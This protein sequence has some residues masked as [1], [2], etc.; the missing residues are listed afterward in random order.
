MCYIASV[1]MTQKKSFTLFLFGLEMTRNSFMDVSEHAPSEA[2][3]VS[4]FDIVLV[5]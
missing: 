5:G 1:E 2:F 4:N 3:E